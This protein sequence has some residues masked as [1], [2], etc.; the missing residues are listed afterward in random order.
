MQPC[1]ANSGEKLEP[2]ETRG[3]FVCQ[4]FLPRSYWRGR[5]DEVKAQSTF[6]GKTYKITFPALSWV[7]KATFSGLG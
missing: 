1:Q 5:G 7:P 4:S 2:K 3:L 6:T